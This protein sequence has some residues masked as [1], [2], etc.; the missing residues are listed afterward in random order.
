MHYSCF[1][2]T[3]YSDYGDDNSSIMKF[4][5]KAVCLYDEPHGQEGERTNDGV[6]ETKESELIG[7]QD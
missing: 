6:E 2:P 1:V 3:R 7:E 5:K 4:L